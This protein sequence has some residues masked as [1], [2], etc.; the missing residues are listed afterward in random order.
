MKKR[1]LEI[2]MADSTLSIVDRS[3]ALSLNETRKKNGHRDLGL[4]AAQLGKYHPK[5]CWDDRKDIVAMIAQ[6]AD[7]LEWKG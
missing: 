7:D 3:G 4:A 1:T 2:M 6:H 5:L